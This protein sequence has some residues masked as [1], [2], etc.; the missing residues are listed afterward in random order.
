MYQE[1]K[2]V[3]PMLTSYVAYDLETSDRYPRGEIVEF[4]AVRVEDGRITGE[5]SE[6]CALDG[7]MNRY[8]SKV[9][10]ITDAMLV[11][12]RPLAEVFA[13]FCKFVG[14]LPMLGF[15]NWS[16]DDNFIDRVAER[17]DISSPVGNGSYD[18]MRLHGRAKLESCCKEYGIVI[19]DAHRALA[20]AR[21]TQLL[22]EAMLCE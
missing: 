8:A 15:N 14:N 7:R 2:Q 21:A 3:F 9:N 17:I 11:G 10:H 19:E 16:F 6:L 20:D 1:T 22:Y 4:G 18:V 12:R 13:D 5:F